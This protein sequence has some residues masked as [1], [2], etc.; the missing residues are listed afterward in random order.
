L[1]LSGPSHTATI[2][3]YTGLV[4]QFHYVVVVTDVYAICRLMQ[5]TDQI[6]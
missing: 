6:W 4:Y 3:H 2:L 5:L 1:N